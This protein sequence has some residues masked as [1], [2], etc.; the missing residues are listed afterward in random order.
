MKRVDI[1]LLL[2]LAITSVA[3]Q[4]PQ[5]ALYGPGT[6]SCGVIVESRRSDNRTF[7]ADLSAWLQG[8]LSGLNQGRAHAAMARNEHYTYRLLPDFQSMLL[9]VEQ[10][11]REHPLGWGYQAAEAMFDSLPYDKSR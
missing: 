3:A 5:R 8:Y 2:G 6:S 11:C 9:F 4:E 10:Y 1:A 7:E